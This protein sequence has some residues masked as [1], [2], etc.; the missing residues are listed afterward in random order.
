[1]QPHVDV[2]TLGVRDLDRSRR[3]YLDGL[4]WAPALDVPGEVLF[5]QVGFGLLLGLY[6]VE[7]LTAEA[8]NV[9]HTELAPPMS[10]G[11]NVS[12]ADDVGAVLAQA[13]SAGGTIISP[14]R[15][16]SW[17]GVS[18]YFAD[19]DGFRWEVAHNPGLTV[20]ADGTVHIGAVE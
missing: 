5:I 10:L 19:P 11:H 14:A 17:G 7:K 16:Q 15:K 9:G 18:G 2:L 20:D 13:E 1:M 6:D 3:F 12:S 4:K 8:G